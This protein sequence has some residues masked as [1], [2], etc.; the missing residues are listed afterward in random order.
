MA[1]AVQDHAWAT[2]AEG[3]ARRTAD[4]PGRESTRPREGLAA[5]RSRPAA[6]AAQCPRALFPRPV[7]FAH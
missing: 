2:S 5:D 7:A 1:A 4:G 3:A 6:L